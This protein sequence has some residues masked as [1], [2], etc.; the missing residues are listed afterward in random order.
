MLAGGVTLAF[1]V[2][3]LTVPRGPV[4]ITIADLAYF[5]L[6]LAAGVAMLAN[7][8]SAGGVNRRFWALM[9][10]GCILWSIDLAA[11]V[12]YEVL[13][14]SDLPNPCVMDMFLFLHLI[15]MIAAVALRP[16]RAE[17]E[18]KSRVGAIDFL[19]L[20]VWWMFRF[21]HSSCSLR[22]TSR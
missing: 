16:H 9:G 21:M 17:G 7:A 11:W 20:L 1:A 5:L 15:P 14:Q 12:Y 4:L 2:V 6:T 13:R 10:S 19:L 8:W 3:S 18:E 22:N